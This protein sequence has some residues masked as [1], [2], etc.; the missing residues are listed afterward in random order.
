MTAYRLRKVHRSLIWRQASHMTLCGSPV[1]LKTLALTDHQFRWIPREYQCDRCTQHTLLH[2]DKICEYGWS[3]T[4]EMQTII[5]TIVLAIHRIGQT[6]HEHRCWFVLGQYDHQQLVCPCGRSTLLVD[7]D[8]DVLPRSWWPGGA[9]FPYAKA[10][11][12][13]RRSLWTI[14]DD[15]GYSGGRP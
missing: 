7:G 5:E 10:A 14:R 11:K 13:W 12:P 3:A 1:P 4:P 8:I 2:V 15:R 6:S 9:L